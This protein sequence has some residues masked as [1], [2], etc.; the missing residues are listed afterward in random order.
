MPNAPT[1]LIVRW[2]LGTLVGTLVVAVTSPLF[3]RSYLPLQVDGMRGVWTLPAGRTYRWRSEGYANTAI[4]PFGMPGR[5]SLPAPQTTRVALWGDSQ[6]EGVCIK[7][8]QKLFAQIQRAGRDKFAVLP[9]ARSGEDASVWLTQMPAMEAELSVD[10][11][12]LLIV[13]LPDLLAAPL[14]PLP[15]PDEQ[16]GQ[17][18][19][20]LAS[21]L[22][23][24]VIQG[25]RNV[26]TEA[27]E[28]TPRR[29]RFS[30]GPV[31][32]SDEGPS[33]L[34]PPQR[35]WSAVATV[36]R[37]TTRLPVLIVYAPLSPQVIGGAAM[38][39]DPAREDF[40]AM[41][42]AANDS[43][44]TVVDMSGPLSES[45]KAGVWPHGF[46]NGVIGAGH[47]NADGYRIIATEVAA[48]IDQV[49]AES[50]N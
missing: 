31:A 38:M 6:A 28:T 27:D 34:M 36:I 35:D 20:S 39:E 26:L 33:D 50:G 41:Q 12:V 22:P 21:T 42:M 45:V 16:T 8:D 9:L 13:D 43:G 11:H 37:R 46:Q 25:A 30:I 19:A 47:L 4:G 2:L 23:A 29:L 24:F 17:A 10:I 18:K 1:R 7:D 14:A 5:T 44:I 32:V 48:V 49:V 40:L 15:R 3:V